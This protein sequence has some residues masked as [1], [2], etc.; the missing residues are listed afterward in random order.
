M[1]N[2]TGLI[3]TDLLILNIA[4]GCLASKN[5]TEIWKTIIKET[6]PK[7]FF[8]LITFFDKPVFNGEIKIEK[9]HID[10]NIFED[11]D[12]LLW[13]WHSPI[14]REWYPYILSLKQDLQILLNQFDKNRIMKTQTKPMQKI[15][16]K[17]G[18]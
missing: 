18:K 2:G 14:S 7:Q 11:I 10:K 4:S 1:I 16:L 9:L 15:I 17:K 12:F 8:N 5:K 6:V 3:N 13:K